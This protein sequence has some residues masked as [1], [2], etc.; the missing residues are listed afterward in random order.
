VEKPPDPWG[1]AGG[2]PRGAPSGRPPEPERLVRLG[3]AFYVAMFGLALLASLALDQSLLFASSSAARAGVSW[4]RDVVAGLAAAVAVVAASALLTDHTRLGARLAD[5]LAQ[6]LGPLRL[7]HCLLLAAASGVGEEALFR[8][9]LQPLVGWVAASLLF[10]LAHFAPR[11]DLLPWTA[12]AVAA[13]F[14]LGALYELTGN[15]VAPVVA[16]AGVN[17]VNLWLLGRRAERGGSASP[18]P[19]R[20][21]PPDAG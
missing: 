3:L 21:D 1:G 6:I 10:G 16:H 12:F 19:R 14:G 5:A 13:G 18:A 11:R 2:G 4:G 7:R 8:G 20:G 15:L 17:A 9:L